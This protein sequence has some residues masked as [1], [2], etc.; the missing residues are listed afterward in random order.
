MAASGAPL[1]ANAGD[2]ILKTSKYAIG[3]PQD[4]LNN[5]GAILTGDLTL[6]SF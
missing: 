3:T 4:L 1:S 5:I 6:L 2:H